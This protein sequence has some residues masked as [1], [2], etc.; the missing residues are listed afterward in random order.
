ME[1]KI[2]AVVFD[3]GGVLLDWDPRYLYRKLFADEQDMERF[4]AEI[5]T[6]EWH[7]SHDRGKRFDV[8]CAELAAQHPQ[9]AAQIHAWGQRSEEMVRGPIDE[10]VEI[11]RRLK[12]SGVPCY[13]LTN[14]ETETYPLRLE[15]FP[16]MR[17]FEGAVVSGFEGVV[18]P[19]REIFVRLLERFKLRPERTLFVDD[20]QR[21]VDA[22]RELGI[23]AVLY[24][25]PQEFE[26]LLSQAGLL[27]AAA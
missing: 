13:A 3:I 4:L 11:L 27:K 1:G 16:F 20:S 12:A 15:R 21:N 18:K 24:R 8:S 10:V 23:R 7:Q 14:M 26:R 2:E 5:C 9:Y 17:W 19:E 6:L 22:A 25:S